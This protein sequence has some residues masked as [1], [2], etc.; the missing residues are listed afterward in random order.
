[1]LIALYGLFTCC[2]CCGQLLTASSSSSA[3][4]H[5]LA[6]FLGVTPQ[7]LS[8]PAVRWG[9]LDV[10]F[11]GVSVPWHPFHGRPLK[12]SGCA[13][14]QRT[15][16]KIVW[17]ARIVA[18]TVTGVGVGGGGGGEGAPAGAESF[19]LRLGR[20]HSFPASHVRRLNQNS[21][22]AISSITCDGWRRDGQTD[23]QL[24]C[25]NVLWAVATAF[26]G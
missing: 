11:C 16:L 26:V 4:R 1:M 10:A 9:L 22:T 19:M 21:S 17:C 24:A 12:F 8:Q 7:R 5:R 18:S 2:S 25:F 14:A 13:A 6:T 3:P 20:R 15:M 23:R